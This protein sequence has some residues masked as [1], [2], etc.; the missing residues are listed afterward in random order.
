MAK[1]TI[2]KASVL[3]D[4][5][6]RLENQKIVVENDK[7]IE[8]SAA[9]SVKADWEGIV[10]PAFIDAHSH[11]GMFR[12]GEPQ[13][14]AEGNDQLSQIMPL[15]DPLNS[16]Y[17][18]D[19]AFRDAVEF[20][21]LY[22]CIVPGSGNL[23]GGKARIIKNFARHR[24]EAL[25][26]DYGYKMALG[27][28]PRGTTGWKGDRPTT[29]MGIYQM[30][31]KRFDEVLAKRRKA[32]LELAKKLADADKAAQKDGLSA[33][34]LKKLR[35]M[36]TAEW[37]IALPSEDLAILDLLSGQKTVKVHV[38]KNDDAYYLIDLVKKY[39]FKAT[40]DHLGDVNDKAVFD[41]LAKAGIRIVYGP[42]GSLA[43]KV[44]LKNEDYRNAGLL[45][46]SKAEY[47]L[48]T[49]HPVILSAALRDSL[50]FFLIQ[51]MSETAALNLIT[52]G[53]ARILGLQ[54]QLGS[55]KA[56]HSAS[57]LVWNREPLSLAAFPKMVMAEGSVI[58]K[59]S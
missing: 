56:G 57:L 28:N 59:Q 16:V 54:D 3:Y 5:A 7:I 44:E 53:N 27:Y 26:A 11:I 39:N 47:G 49:D 1:P 9:G 31:E 45:M 37:T 25:L 20:G 24:N 17:F 34:E 2:I 40:A 6:T 58:R 18:D 22:S 10:T 8:V 19:R 32:E 42:L 46:K 4:G 35:E 43:Y 21:V 36:A 41:A 52:S 23:V 14:E 13:S 33:A 12:E 29:R 50:K 30:L 38:H 48:M 55:I 15:S 51:G